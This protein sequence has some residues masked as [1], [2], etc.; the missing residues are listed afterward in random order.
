[1]QSAVLSIKLGPEEG[2]RNGW[3][4]S[5]WGDWLTAGGEARRRIGRCGEDYGALLW[6][7]LLSF[8][9]VD[10]RLFRL[11]LL[12]RQTGDR[13]MHIILVDGAEV[14]LLT[15]AKAKRQ[16]VSPGGLCWLAGGRAWQALGVQP[17]ARDRRGESW[18]SDLSLEWCRGMV[19]RS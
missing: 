18:V 10:F 8:P 11:G 7:R 19:H 17:K 6:G 4:K 3:S 13:K 14:A 12:G 1:M 2:W 9:Y 16:D 5:G 15:S